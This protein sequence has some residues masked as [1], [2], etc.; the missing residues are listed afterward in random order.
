M[1]QKVTVKEGGRERN[2]SLVRRLKTDK[3]DGG[4]CFWVPEN[5]RRLTP[6]YA[7]ENGDYTPENGYYA[8]S[9]VR[10]NVMNFD[11]DNPDIDIE[12]DDIDLPHIDLPDIDITIDE[13]GIPEISYGIHIITEDED[14]I[15]VILP[16]G[17]KIEIDDSDLTEPINIL[18]T[19]EIS[20]DPETNT[21]TI[22]ALTDCTVGDDTFRPGE[23]IKQWPGTESVDFVIVGSV[24]IPD[25]PGID[26]LIDFDEDIDISIDPDIGEISISG[27]DLD[28]F[29]AYIDIDLNTFEID[30]NDCPA[31][32]QIMHTPGTTE[33]TDSHAIDY[34]G[35]VVQAFDRN[36]N[37]WTSKEYP[38]GYIPAHKLSLPQYADITQTKEHAVMPEYMTLDTL[39]NIE[40][41]IDPGN[42]CDIFTDKFPVTEGDAEYQA[43]MQEGIDQM[44]REFQDAVSEAQGIACYAWCGDPPPGGPVSAWTLH[45]WWC[46]VVSIVGPPDS[47]GY[48]NAVI[49]QWGY[50]KQYT[51]E[52]GLAFHGRYNGRYPVFQGIN[53]QGWYSSINAGI[54]NVQT[55]NVGWETPCMQQL[56]ASFDVTVNAKEEHGGSHHSGQF[57][58]DD[59]SENGHWGGTTVSGDHGGSH[60]SGYF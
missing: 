52:F 59:D 54:T 50:V 22:K 12:I 31:G 35:L 21:W 32:I 28:G 11:F 45:N 10:A 3:Q 51:G 13:I 46:G 41:I 1:S 33:Y 18:D 15:I 47:S 5:E 14:T 43:L 16:G 37:V 36:G 23:I 53:S 57:G 26:D 34:D 38:D 56:S 9:E 25:I 42:I 60:S 19:I 44:R 55:V 20:Y 24:A 49:D 29:P 40:S 2:F 17:E 30:D 4:A 8:F 27:L 58:Y 6:L 39:K 48:C 7:M